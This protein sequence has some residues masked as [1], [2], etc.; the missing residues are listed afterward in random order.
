MKN[1]WQLDREELS[2]VREWLKLNKD[3]Q[4]RRC[5]FFNIV[6]KRCPGVDSLGDIRM[7]DNACKPICAAAFRKVV[8]VVLETVDG[9][10]REYCECP[11]AQYPRHRVIRVARLLLSRKGLFGRGYAKSQRDKKRAAAQN[12]SAVAFRGPD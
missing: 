12:E 9:Q 1:A 2:G 7:W 8:P 4:H 5:P 11:C 3:H 6:K 10:R